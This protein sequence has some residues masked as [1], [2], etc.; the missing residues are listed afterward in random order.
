[1]RA[2][3]HMKEFRY[4]CFNG[5][6]YLE[7]PDIDILHTFQ[8]IYNALDPDPALKYSVV[9]RPKNLRRSVIEHF[10]ICG[11]GP[12]LQAERKGLELPKGPSYQAQV[13]DLH[14]KKAY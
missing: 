3:K 12:S 5:G 13:Q 4:K 2:S 11:P 6:I 8:S 14:L 9:R 7:I 10:D 1:M